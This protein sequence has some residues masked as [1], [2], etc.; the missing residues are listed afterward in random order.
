MV[1]KRAMKEQRKREKA[2]AKSKGG[3]LPFH[4][5]EESLRQAYDDLRL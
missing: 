3:E 2:L 5:Q 1:M 4:L